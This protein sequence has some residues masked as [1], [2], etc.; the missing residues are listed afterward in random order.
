[1]SEFVDSAFTVQEL[2]DELMK[3][4]DKSRR[5]FFERDSWSLEAIRTVY[6]S[7]IEEEKDLIFIGP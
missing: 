3:V 7:G 5:V 6:G 1:M 4:E 2:I